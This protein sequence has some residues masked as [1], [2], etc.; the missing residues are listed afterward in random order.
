MILKKYIKTKRIIRFQIALNT[1]LMY[2]IREE[3]KNLFNYCL[4]RNKHCSPQFFSIV[5]PIRTVFNGLYLYIN[6]F[7]NSQVSLCKQSA[8]TPNSR[9]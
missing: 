7:N 9:K 3:P 4:S 8:D 1:K 2:S 6:I 5:L